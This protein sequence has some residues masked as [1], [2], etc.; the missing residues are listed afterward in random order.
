M[1]KKITG[2]IARWRIRLLHWIVF[3]TTPTP[4]AKLVG[5]TRL[6]RATENILETVERII[7]IRRN[8]ESYYRSTLLPTWLILGVIDFISKIALS[9]TGALLDGEI[10]HLNKLKILR[11]K[12][13]AASQ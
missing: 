5:P 11:Q 2:I 9:I 10:R 1:G 7:A 6:M 3:G 4:D 12:Y 8:S 13:I